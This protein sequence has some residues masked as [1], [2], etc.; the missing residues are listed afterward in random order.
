MIIKQNKNYIIVFSICFLLF[1]YFMLDTLGYTNMLIRLI[2]EPN[3][4]NH[5]FVNND[6]PALRNVSPTLINFIN[7]LCTNS[8]C[9][10][11]ELVVFGTA[12]FQVILPLVSVVA[13]IDFYKYYHSLFPMQII[14][15][16]NYKK[17]I[18]KCISFKSF[19]LA[20]SVFFAYFLFIIIVQIISDPSIDVGGRRSFLLDIFG[21]NLYHYKFL[22]YFLEGSI[23]FFMMPFV[24][25]FLIQSTVLYFQNIKEV[26][27]TPIVYYYLLTLIG[28]GCAVFKNNI[29][30]YLSPAAMMANGAFMNINSLL[31]IF[32]NSFPLFIGLIL[33]YRKFSGSYEI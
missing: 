26:V 3:Y 13:G 7:Y 25:S 30:I 21:N 14:K 29:Y 6:N 24:Y 1:I 10:F 31:L 11:D 28:Y 27:A 22:Y 20:L 8:Y 2:I 15:E 32:T 19:K 16:E 23:R 9:S 17:H 4:L 12:F 33:M 18:I 5:F